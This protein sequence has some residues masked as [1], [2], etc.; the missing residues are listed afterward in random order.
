MC[1]IPAA[2]L[3][4]Q[5]TLS[6]HA[7]H[8][9]N[10]YLGVFTDLLFDLERALCGKK[11]SE[12]QPLS[13]FCITLAL[14]YH[15]L[16]HSCHCLQILADRALVPPTEN[17]LIRICC[18]NWRIFTGL[19][20]NKAFPP[21]DTC[22]SLRSDPGAVGRV[23]SYLAHMAPGQGLSYPWINLTEAC[24]NLKGSPPEEPE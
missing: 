12:K 18:T 1:M 16:H 6:W 14:P 2:K 17:S 15:R 10:S 23:E 9:I 24:M 11:G 4:P 8:H 13:V 22:S 19:G 7:I 20:S 21:R 5:Q 3:Q